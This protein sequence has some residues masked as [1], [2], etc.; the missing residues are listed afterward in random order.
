MHPDTTETTSFPTPTVTPSVRPDSDSC[1]GEESSRKRTV[2][3][4]TFAAAMTA[5][6]VM[7][8]ALVVAVLI[9]CCCLCGCCD[10]QMCKSLTYLK[11]GKR[12]QKGS[13]VV[14]LRISHSES[15]ST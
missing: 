10:C 4:L 3:V 14:M 12:A 2:S 9:L 11:K 8:V 6:A 15:F 1:N 5:S 7:I 13:N